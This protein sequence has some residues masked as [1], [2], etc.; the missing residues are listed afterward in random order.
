MA[1]LFSWDNH[2]KGMPMEPISSLHNPLVKYLEKLK[3]R[4]FR[5]QEERFAVEGVRFVEEA[6]RSGWPV[7]R[8]VYS[9][10]LPG[11][12]RG[13]ELLS[14]AEKAGI[15]TTPVEKKILDA[16]ACTESPQGVL[17][18]CRM[19]QRQLQDL[20]V[21][22][23]AGEDKRQG[24]VVVVDGVGDPGNLGTIIRSAHAFGA[25][26]AVLLKG[27]VDLYNDKSLRATMGS[28]FHLPVLSGVRPAE[29]AEHLSAAGL[30]L[31]VG[32]PAGGEPVDGLDAGRP[33]ALVVGGEA[34]G[35]SAEL[36]SIPHQKVTIPMPGR[37]E[38][39]NVA[40]AASV[41]LYEIAR[42]RRGS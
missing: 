17:A 12:A 15:S 34:G 25:D 20:A 13:A 22:V 36:L 16:L 19:V 11:T 27:T 7:E 30:S 9:P 39:L 35:P 6:L 3:K 42:Q 24:L 31:L 10:G 33:L 41:L 18:L 14:L 37:A 4:R 23:G 21:G 29:L 28:V 5:D 40:V 38:S 8:L 32:V 1:M 2:L 26:G